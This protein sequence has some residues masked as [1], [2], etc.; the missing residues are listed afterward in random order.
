MRPCGRT[1]LLRAR[2]IRRTWVT[3]K[4]QLPAIHYKDVIISTMASQNQITGA[5]VVCTNVCSSADQRKHRSSVSLAFLRENQRWPGDSPLK[6]PLTRIFFH[7]M[8]SAWPHRHACHNSIR[9]IVSLCIT[10]QKWCAQL[11][12]Y[13]VFSSRLYKHTS[14]QLG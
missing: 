10:Y 6:G 2:Y 7:L 8:T 1:F 14:F 13:C 11:T 5:S 12:F 3:T 4:L 9:Y